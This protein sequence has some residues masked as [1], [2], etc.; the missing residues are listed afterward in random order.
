MFNFVRNID[1][2]W[3]R[4]ITRVGATLMVCAAVSIACIS[5]SDSNVNYPPLPETNYPVD[6]QTGFQSGG[7]GMPT[8]APVEELET[9]SP[10]G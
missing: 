1:G 8:F 6:G 4:Q 3:V 2:Y 9:V 5:C 7:S 10:A